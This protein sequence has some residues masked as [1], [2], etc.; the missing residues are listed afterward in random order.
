M[1]CCALS[2][3][4]TVDYDVFTATVQGFAA[5][6]AVTGV[7][8]AYLAFLVLAT[9]GSTD[10]VSHAVDLGVAIGFLPGLIAAGVVFVDAIRLLPG[11]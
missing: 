1:S 9:G 5:L 4:T 11:S 3:A 8:A 6:G 10:D 7:S 2:A